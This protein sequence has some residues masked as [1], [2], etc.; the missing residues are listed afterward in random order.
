MRTAFKNRSFRPTAAVLAAICGLALSVVVSQASAQTDVNWVNPVSGSWG[1][2]SNWSSNPFIP[3][4][5]TPSGATYRAIFAGSGSYIVT[6]SQAVSLA[7]LRLD[8]QGMTLSQTS[9]GS[10]SISGDAEL[11]RGTYLVTGSTASAARWLIGNGTLRLSGG[12]LIGGEVLRTGSGRFEMTGTENTLR[13]VTFTGAFSPTGLAEARAAVLDTFTLNGSWTSTAGN[14][15]L[16]FN[17]AQSTGGALTVSGAG[18]LDLIGTASLQSALTMSGVVNVGS[19]WAIQGGRAS[20]SGPATLNIA[21][22]LSSNLAGD[23]LTIAS[24]VTVNSS[25]TIEALNG[26][27][28]LFNGG[29]VS[30]TGVLRAGAGSTI[31]FQN[32]QVVFN[33]T[34]IDAAGGTVAFSQGSLNLSG[35]TLLQNATSGVWTFAGT[36]ISNGSIVTGDGVQFAL[37]ATGELQNVNFSGAMNVT[38]NSVIRGG[39]TAGTLHVGS[40]LLQVFDSWTSTAAVTIADGMQLSNSGTGVVGPGF[41]LT[42]PTGIFQNSGTV[43]FSG[44]TFTFNAASPRWQGGG[45]LRNGVLEV[46]D[47]RS[48]EWTG[49]ALDDMA[50][51]GTLTLSGGRDIV[52]KNGL[53]GGPQRGQI[54]AA[55]GSQV[56]FFISGIQQVSGIDFVLGEGSIL[57]RTNG[58]AN[59]AVFDNTTT[60]RGYGSVGTQAAAGVIRIEGLLEANVTGQRLSVGAGIFPAQ[61]VGTMRAS[62]GGELSVGLA[63]ALPTLDF[64][65]SGSAI[66]INNWIVSQPGFATS[67]LSPITYSG[68]ELEI[69]GETVNRSTVGVING[70]LLFGT[71]MSGST[72]AA[73]NEGTI[74]AAGSTVKLSGPWTNVAGTINLTDSRLEL[75]GSFTPAVFGTINR[76]NSDVVVRGTWNNAGRTYTIDGPNGSLLINGGQISDG[77]IVTLGGGTLGTRAGYTGT[78]NRITMNGDLVMNG[79]TLIAN[80][81]SLNGAT[82]LTNGAVLTLNDIGNV[83]W[84]N[85]GGI[86]VA[87]SE[88]RLGGTV[89][90]ARIGSITRSGTGIVSLSGVLNASTETITITPTTMLN[91]LAGGT[92]YASAVEFTDSATISG[93]GLIETSLVTG[94]GSIVATGNF[95]LRGPS[96]GTLVVDPDIVVSG[97]FGLGSSTSSVVFRGLAAVGANIGSTAFIGLTFRNE[98]V[99]EVPVGTTVS[100]IGTTGGSDPT[101]TMI[102][103][104][105]IVLNGGILQVGGDFTRES[106]GTIEYHAGETRIY[107]RLD[108]RGDLL[109]LTDDPASLRTT[110]WGT[111]LGGQVSTSGSRDLRITNVDG[112]ELVGNVPFTDLKVYNSLRTTGVATFMRAERQLL[113]TIGTE[114]RLGGAFV[115]SALGEGNFAHTGSGTLILEPDFSFRGSTAAFK[116]TT[117]SDVVTI[118]NEG[119]ITADG[120]GRFTIDPKVFENYGTIE[121]VNGAGILVGAPNLT[122]RQ[123]GTLRTAAGA[124]MRVTG[125]IETDGSGFENAGLITLSGN[126]INTGAPVRFDNDTGSLHLDLNVANMA[127]ESIGDNVALAGANLNNVT[128]RGN[129]VIGGADITNGLRNEGVMT[130]LGGST[131]DF[132]NTQTFSGGEVRYLGTASNNTMNIWGG[133]VLTIDSDVLIRGGRLTIGDDLGT[134]RNGLVHAGTIVAD[135]PSQAIS[136]LVDDFTNAGTLRSTN[137]SSI[138]VSGGEWSLPGAAGVQRW[139]NPGQ[140]ITDGGSVELRGHFASDVFDGIE[141]ISGDLILSG[142]VD[143]TGRTLTL[144]GPGE[145]IR[146][147]AGLLRYHVPQSLGLGA[148]IVGGTL[149]LRNGAN[150]DTGLDGGAVGLDSVTVNGPMTLD[151]NLEMRNVTF[152]DLVTVRGRITIERENL[153]SQVTLSSGHFFID[154]ARTDGF[155]DDNLVIGPSVLIHGRGGTMERRDSGASTLINYGR[156]ITDGPNFYVR[157]RVMENYGILEAINGARLTVNGSA[158]EFAWLNHG[159]LRV[160][161]STLEVRGT[162]NT[163]SLVDAEFLN[164]NI[165]LWDSLENDGRTLAVGAN[166]TTWTLNGGTIKGG[167]IE[168]LPGS[169]FTVNASATFDGVRLNGDFTIAQENLLSFYRDTDLHGTMHFTHPGTTVQVFSAS[170]DSGTFAFENPGLSVRNLYAMGSTLHLGEDA[171]IRGGNVRISQPASSSI[172]NEGRISADIADSTITVYLARF[173]NLGVMESLNGGSLVLVPPPTFF[174]DSLLINDGLLRIDSFSTF[175]LDGDFQQSDLGMLSIMLGGTDDGPVSGIFAVS[176]TAF[177]EGGLRLEL[178]NGFEPLDGHRFS[179]LAAGTFMGEFDTLHLPSLSSGLR[180]DTS[181]LY[182]DGSVGVVPAPASAALLAVMGLWG[183][184]RRRAVGSGGVL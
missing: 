1:V 51:D 80:G 183:T 25:G 76:T 151:G 37:S 152:T 127:I 155:Y 158:Q 144:D 44:G 18:T 88:L 162:S 137:A 139:T 113:E 95:G 131:L 177:L 26:G 52:V 74:N 105:T 48:F 140:I 176:G 17:G 180:W 106:L 27:T 86:T 90:S 154:G 62:N 101:P 99:I 172:V 12:T 91:R 65:G 146:A 34:T 39:S 23:T 57:V 31:R 119:L 9:G 168:V 157:H 184:R 13:G 36:R 182:S 148:R 67:I 64:A 122:V 40:S 150:I 181:S 30:S 24:N 125:N 14:Y 77:T 21:G 97:R 111:I 15:N 20:V 71:S 7:A 6:L 108:N 117:L 38:G 28:L 115:P 112:V 134:T 124:T 100:V 69:G 2:A 167:T 32:S 104:G 53:S 165:M 85:N 133:S 153:R 19:A 120:T 33:G 60:I 110:Q 170:L 56:E 54:V 147:V 89:T 109:E 47:G 42:G 79:G 78:L 164:A 171:V 41:S 84:A 107:G 93:A 73:R 142:R 156:I 8:A 103:T 136:I 81:V 123:R 63:G 96:G 118:R 128:L 3:N 129:F 72:F 29:P 49:V 145:T 174:G 102:N 58:G 141:R 16:F 163:Q 160:I 116:Q 43:D 83:L 82:S 61:V 46:R 68:G 98:G 179:V 159:L 173:N 130:S 5:G 161:D 126:L 135:I 94:Q 66:R 169:T 35:G 4:N 87:D 178:A 175:S 114:V 50:L 121:S 45:A 166:G 132:L 149:N 70:T 59:G 11:L 143:N 22:K 10:M 92:I 138:V 75:F 55:V